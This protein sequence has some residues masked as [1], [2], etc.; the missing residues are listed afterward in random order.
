MRLDAATN[1]YALYP[2]GIALHRA[3]DVCEEFRHYNNF[4]F[5]LLDDYCDGFRT[6]GVRSVTS[7]GEFV[8]AYAGLKV[9]AWERGYDFGLP[10]QAA[11]YVSS[12]VQGDSG[13]ADISTRVPTNSMRL[14]AAYIE[15]AGARWT[16]SDSD[17]YLKIRTWFESD[18][19]GRKVL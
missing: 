10:G 3:D 4:S 19:V 5:P 6:P 12:I 1:S 13:L 18:S 11:A 15:A 17:G 7:W 9:D 16:D 8:A 2:V 14:L